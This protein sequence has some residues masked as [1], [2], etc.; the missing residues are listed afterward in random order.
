ML[1]AVTAEAVVDN[2]SVPPRAEELS[3]NGRRDWVNGVNLIETC[4][5]TH[6]TA[7]L[8]FFMDPCMIKF[9][10]T[11]F[12]SGLAPEIAHFKHPLDQI[13]PDQAPNGWYIKGWQYVNLQSPLF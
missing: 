8:V 12:Y 3:E 4:M 9:T 11:P 6:E 1:G 5:L 2:V 13:D 7:T 10:L